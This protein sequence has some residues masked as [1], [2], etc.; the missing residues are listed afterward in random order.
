MAIYTLMVQVPDETMQEDLIAAVDELE[1]DAGL[2]R[3]RV[4]VTFCGPGALVESG[5]AVCEA[6]GEPVDAP[7]GGTG[8]TLCEDCDLIAV[9][10]VSDDDGPLDSFSGRR[11]ARVARLLK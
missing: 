6:C 8:H 3:V 9:A 1:I 4:E 10:L 5:G 2:A 11:V 7:H